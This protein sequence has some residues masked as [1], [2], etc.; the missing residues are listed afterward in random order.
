MQKGIIKEMKRITSAL[1]WMIAILVIVPIW[2]FI[3]FI[4]LISMIIGIF[5][6]RHRLNTDTEL[7]APLDYHK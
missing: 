2:L 3:G 6:P 4:G 7:P 5:I 1:T